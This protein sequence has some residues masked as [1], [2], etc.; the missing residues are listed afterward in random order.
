MSPPN[1][2]E[3][4]ERNLVQ[5]IR[6]LVGTASLGCEV[7]PGDDAAVLR[8]GAG[9]R[10]WSV[11][12]QRE[13][14]H[15]E[16]CWLSRGETG[17]RAVT[18]ASSDIWAMGAEP[19]W[20]LCA[21]ELPAGLPVTEF[22]EL[23]RGLRDG[24]REAGAEIVG[25]D[26]GLADTLGLVTTVGGEFAP[27]GEPLLRSGARLGDELWV[28]GDLGWAAA[29]RALLATGKAVVDEHEASCVAAFRRPRTPAAFCR[30]AA[31]APE[32]HGMMDISD[33][34]GIDVHRL[35]EESRVGAEVN[36]D[37]LADAVPPSAAAAAGST[38]LELAL[39]GGDDYA[40]LCAISPGA[41]GAVAAAA[42]G[43]PVRRIG[44]VTDAAPGIV[45]LV[46]DRR[47]ALP[48]TGWDPFRDHAGG[49]AE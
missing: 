10:A 16:S 27:G 8:G 44:L 22:E 25:G 4:G 21:L 34:L 40:M 36:G 30:W 47:R 28:V 11:D 46:G 20:V 14:T 37:T 15:F 9:Q 48:A 1:V 29:G 17:H 3:L 2:G 43:F 39:C 32:V 33:G 19:R 24:A 12:R 6:R 23:I 42:A 18:I 26:V 7:G 5:V 49:A 41:G 35:C 31:V 13:G 45:L 38:S